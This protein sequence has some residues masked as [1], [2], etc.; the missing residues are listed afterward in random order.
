MACGIIGVLAAQVVD[1]S[2]KP[3]RVTNPNPNTADDPAQR[4]HE[5]ELS[6]GLK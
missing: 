5:A 1:P 6:E 4:I 3:E 2:L